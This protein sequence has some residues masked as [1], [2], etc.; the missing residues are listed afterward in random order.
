MFK[1]FNVVVRDHVSHEYLNCTPAQMQ[2]VEDKIVENN[3]K[4]YNRAQEG[5]AK[6][7]IAHQI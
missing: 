7:S 3:T 1:K 5:P 6:T 2:S 4:A